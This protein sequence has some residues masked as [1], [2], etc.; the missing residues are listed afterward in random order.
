MNKYRVVKKQVECTFY[1]IPAKDFQEA[2]DKYQENGDDFIVGA[3][4]EDDIVEE[5][6]ANGVAEEE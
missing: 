2:W 1:D 4:Y 5:I 6:F 3:A